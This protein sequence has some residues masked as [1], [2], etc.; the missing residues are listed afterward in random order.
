MRF[1]SR[2]QEFRMQRYISKRDLENE[3]SIVLPWWREAGGV[4]C[5]E[6]AGIKSRL[7]ATPV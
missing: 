6:L 4:D 2:R 1:F 5:P 3:G 7:L